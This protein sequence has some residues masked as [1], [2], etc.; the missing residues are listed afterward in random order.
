MLGAVFLSD[1]L[2]V[3]TIRI[4]P[5]LQVNFRGLELDRCESEVPV[6]VC[7]LQDLVDHAAHEGLDRLKRFWEIFNVPVFE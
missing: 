7:F 4:F 6:P 1:D 5:Y 3:I 2:Y